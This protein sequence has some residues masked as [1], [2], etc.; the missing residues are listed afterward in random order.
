[1]K[2]NP[3]IQLH[4]LLFETMIVLLTKQ[5]I[6]EQPYSIIVL[7][8]IKLLHSQDDKYSLKYLHAARNIDVNNKPVSPIMS[9]D[10]ETLV[11]QEAADKNSF[12]LIKT[13]TSQML[14]LRAP[15]SSECK[16]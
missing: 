15:S 10:S 13:K 6:Q 5:V 14:E 11:R 8:N 2:K 7:L 16:T 4:G 12:F 1:M 3:S 9:I